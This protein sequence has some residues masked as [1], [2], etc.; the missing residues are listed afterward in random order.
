M[1]QLVISIIWLIYIFLPGELLLFLIVRQNIKRYNFL[2]HLCLVFGFG[3]V[4]STFL[5]FSLS[6]FRILSLVTY[7]ITNLLFFVP[8]IYILYKYYLKNRL[9]EKFRV[10]KKGII[11]LTIIVL[12]LIYM[13]TQIIEFSY[14]TNGDTYYFMGKSFE[15]FYYQPDILNAYFLG[16]IRNPRFGEFF[17]VN[18]LFIFDKNTFVN[19]VQIELPI[20]LAF[21]NFICFYAIAKKISKHGIPIYFLFLLIISTKIYMTYLFTFAIHNVA[22]T[23]ILLFTFIIFDQK[24]SKLKI[25]IFISIIVYLFHGP[26]FLFFFISIIPFFIISGFRYFHQ[27]NYTYRHFPQFLSNFI[28]TIKREF[29]SLIKI[30]NRKLVKI[31]FLIF[32]G[33]LNIVGYFLTPQGIYIRPMSYKEWND[34]SISFYLSLGAIILSFRNIYIYKFKRKAFEENFLLLISLSCIVFFTTINGIYWIAEYFGLPYIY[35]R[36]LKYLDVYVVFVLFFFI[37]DIYNRLKTM[38]DQHKKKNSRNLSK[39]ILYNTIIAVIII[40]SSFSLA[41]NVSSTYFVIDWGTRTPTSFITLGKWLGSNSPNE[42]IIALPYENFP[43]FPSHYGSFLF[44]DRFVVSWDNTKEYFYKDWRYQTLGPEYFDFL[45]WVYSGEKRMNS[46]SGII[47]F[48]NSNYKTN[49]TIDYIIIYDIINPRL[50]ALMENDSANFENI[51]EINY[52]ERG[53]WTYYPDDSIPLFGKFVIYRVNHSNSSNFG[54]EGWTNAD[55][56]GCASVVVPNLD[57]HKK[58]VQQ[59]DGNGTTSATIYVDFSAQS[60][61]TVE[62]WW[63]MDDITNG[64]FIQFDTAGSRAITLL[65][66]VL[67]ESFFYFDGI[68]SKWSAAVAGA[69]DNVW[70][71]HKIVFDISTDTFDWYIDGVLVE[72][73]ANFHNTQVTGITRFSLSTNPSTSAYNAFYDVVGFS[74]DPNYNFS[75]INPK[76]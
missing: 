57:G 6:L 28:N 70:T 48:L 73:D 3:I 47:Q 12:I 52:T 72:D 53:F 34:F 15:I 33:S 58:V 20:L 46:H 67:G 2:E 39:I 21:I 51:Y 19:F 14:I 69:S 68:A 76:N 26:T 22:F 27:F 40:N 56:A 10:T 44:Y 64:S 9:Q 63:R 66:G 74:W 30:F 1:I 65:S 41:S 31:I 37:K 45:E 54:S 61:G 7:N 24:L 55:G 42:T 17:L 13:Y 8:S 75:F 36:Y 18:F 5:V 60:S 62:I 49:K 32:I 23:L 25:L 71:H 50:N 43:R 35:K 4:Y 38:K 29:P 59:F 16:D 11:T